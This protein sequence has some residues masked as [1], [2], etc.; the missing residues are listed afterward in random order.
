MLFNS[1]ERGER[2]IK[3]NK[4][5]NQHI[6][7]QENKFLVL[8]TIRENSS[9]S[10]ADIATSTGLNKGTVSSLVTELLNDK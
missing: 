9:I 10:S 1:G 3:V 4:T 6:V 7:K 8:R 5:W 2:K